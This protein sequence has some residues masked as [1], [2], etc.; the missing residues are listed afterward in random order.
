M[1]QYLEQ[2]MPV[3]PSGW[4][5]MHTLPCVLRLYQLGHLSTV[6]L[7]Q[8]CS[9]QVPAGPSHVQ[10]RK[11]ARRRCRL[12]PLR[13]KAT[14]PFSNYIHTICAGFGTVLNFLNPLPWYYG[15]ID[16]VWSVFTQKVKHGRKQVLWSD[17][18]NTSII[19]PI[20]EVRFTDTFMEP[21]KERDSPD[22]WSFPTW[23]NALN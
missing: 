10:V 19:F 3:S 15:V 9:E 16:I 22:F 6:K 1:K 14:H 23:S 20:S 17:L 18:R 11:P 13:A 2:D 8:P 7:F 5:S 12:C 4:G 21:P